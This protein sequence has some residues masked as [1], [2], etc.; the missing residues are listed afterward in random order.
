[1]KLLPASLLFG[2]TFGTPT[3]T[4]W[5]FEIDDTVYEA[6]VHP[7]P[8]GFWESKAFCDGFGAGWQLP[9]PS[10]GAEVGFQSDVLF[11]IIINFF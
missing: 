8:R 5:Q 2:C 7:V 10:N 9:T 4:Q 6:L 11:V 3:V 1:M